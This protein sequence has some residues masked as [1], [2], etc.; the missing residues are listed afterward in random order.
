VAG[1]GKLEDTNGNLSWGRSRF[2]KD[3]SAIGCRYIII[4]DVFFF[5]VP[6]TPFYPKVLNSLID[7]SHFAVLFKNVPP[8]NSKNLLY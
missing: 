6:V 7:V 1:E 5:L 3:H 2:V 8:S 4:I